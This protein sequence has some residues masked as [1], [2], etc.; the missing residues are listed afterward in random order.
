MKKFIIIFFIFLLSTTVYAQD[1]STLT[2][3]WPLNAGP[4]NPHLY[5][6]NQMYAQTMVY[7]S[8]V[9]YTPDGMEGALAESW[10]ISDDGL[11]YTFKLRNAKFSDGSPVTAEAVVMNFNAVMQNKAR[12]SW[13]ALVSMIESFSAKDDKTFILKLSKPYNLTLKELSVARPF[14]I[15]APNGFLDNKDTSKGIKAPIGSGP[16]KLKET[17]LGEYD[18]FERNEYYWG[19]KPKY[20]YVKVLVLPDANSRIIALETGKIDMLLG[21]GSF[22]IEN[23][24]RLSKNKDIAAYKS[25]PRVTNM[26]ALNTARNNTKDVNV[27][28]AVMMAVNKDNIIKYIL[29]NQ[30]IKAEQIFN[31]EL[32]YCNAG[33]IPYEYN[34]NK[35]NEILENAGWKKKGLYREKDGQVLSIDMHYIGIDPKQKAIAE[36]IQ[37]DLMQAGIKLNLVAEESTI[38][39]S[40]QANGSFD[41][42]FNKT[43][44]PPFDPGTFTGSMRKPSHADYQA[45][46]GLKEKADIDNM[47][48]QL[49]IS[50]NN[51]FIADKYKEILNIFHNEA[52][53]LPISY[54]LDLALVRKDRVKNFQ[55]GNMVTEFMLHT[56]EPYND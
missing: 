39:Y 21:E 44:G 32:E 8:L 47:I 42:I 23:F 10:H 43:W 28:K 14:R 7:D 46:S 20:K 37:A 17:K 16:W 29:L 22:T 4:V 19:Q 50:D 31:P 18:I 45:Q 56:L 26:I 38:F 34:I 3:A 55:F 30:E 33:I 11:T 40:L 15:L 2:I 13:I 27:R 24:V 51:T 48:S 36:I 1:D 54:E 35:A 41:M 5:N 12:H 9:R 49:I 52:V 25:E 53:Y 6:P